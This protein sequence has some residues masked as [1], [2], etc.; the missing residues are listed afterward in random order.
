MTLTPPPDKMPND[1]TALDAAARRH[2]RLTALMAMQGMTTEGINPDTVLMDQCSMGEL[3]T[4]LNQ[5]DQQVALAVQESLPQLVPIVEA[6]VEAFKQGGRLIY[7]GAGTSGRLGLLDAVECVPTFGTKPERVQALMAGGEGAFVRAVE[8]AEDDIVQGKADM[9]ALNPT[10]HDVVVGVSASGQAPY[11]RAALQYARRE[12]ATAACVVNHSKALLI[13]DV[14]YPVIVET[15]PE[16]VTGSTRMKAGT[17]QKMVLNM[18]STAAMVRWGRTY[19][20]VMVD[21]LTTNK[22]LHQRARRIVMGLTQVTQLQAEEALERCGYQVKTAVMMCQFQVS[23]E[24][25]LEMIQ[26]TEGHIGPWLD[27]GLEALLDDV[28]NKDVER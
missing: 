19:G 2:E 12:G 7:V 9:S 25:A 16:P 23:P 22:K 15:G 27:Q 17:S 3:L 24:R 18:L 1:R 13:Q 6:V 11:V 14:T 20:N 8:G 26:E 10:T 5:Q 28:I 21:V 4:M